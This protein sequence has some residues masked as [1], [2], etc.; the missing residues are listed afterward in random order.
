M[1][2]SRVRV[3]DARLPG[4]VLSLLG[5]AA[6]VSCVQMDDWK[7]V[8]GG[9]DGLVIVWDKRMAAKLWELHNR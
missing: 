6:P 9:G 8:S 7:V 3:Y 4:P 2:N 1:F 5:H